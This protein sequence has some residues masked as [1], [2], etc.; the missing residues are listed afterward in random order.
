MPIT[1][2]EFRN[3]ARRL[4]LSELAIDYVSQAR[5]S[6]PARR[7]ESNEVNNTVWR[8]PSAKMG[9]TVALESSEEFT[10]AIQLEYDEEVLEYWEQPPSVALAVSDKRGRL[11]R[12]HYVPDFLVIR[13]S[14]VQVVQ[15]KPADQCERLSHE[16]PHRWSW[17][18]GVADDTAASERFKE[19]GLP[20]LVY[21]S[22]QAHKIRAD[23]YRLLL[24]VRGAGVELEVAR[25][26]CKAVAALSVDAVISMGQLMLSSGIT[27]ATPVVRLVELG[28]LFTDLDRWRLSAPDE[29]FISRSKNAIGAHVSAQIALAGAGGMVSQLSSAEL[30]EAHHRLLTIRGEIQTHRSRRSISR[31]RKR[32]QASGGDVLGLRPHH[33]SKGNRTPRLSDGEEGL[34]TSSLREHYL[35]HLCTSRFAAYGQYLVDHQEA[36][37]R[38][39]L[40][41]SSVPV[42]YPT[43][44]ARIKRIPKEQLAAERSGKRAAAA[45]AQP[46]APIF[47]RLSSIRAF[48]RAHVDHYLCDIH[49]VIAEGEKRYTRRPQLT[50]MR[51][52]ATGAVL[53]V[54][55][56]FMPP[57]RR[58][59]LSVIRDCVRRHGRLPETIVVD[60]GAEFHSEYF[61]VVLA[62]LGVAIQRRPPGRPRYGSTIEAWFHSLKAFLSAQHGNTNN[63][64]RGR[65]A[66]ASHK[67]RAHAAWTLFE[68]YSA[69]DRFAFELFNSSAARSDV[70]SRSTKSENALALFP[71]S[72]VSVAFDSEFLAL[73]A[74]PLKRPL[75][76]D[77]ARGIR[78]LGRWFSHSKLFESKNYDTRLRVFEEPWDMNTLYADVN[79]VLVPCRY[80]SL[81]TV[82]LTKDFAP[83][84]ESIRN[85][86]CSDV[87]GLLLKEQTV[88]S[89][90]L[91]RLLAE[92]TPAKTA[93]PE[94]ATRSTTRKRPKKRHIAAAALKTEY[95]S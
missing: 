68:A 27:T 41:K 95:W 85:L 57:S 81:S 3:Y 6:A 60:N 33:R 22:G 28:E 14:E 93:T 31:W 51:D 84:L 15:V 87:R 18:K 37:A 47:K 83:A 73:T 53:A 89:A 34:L 77:F 54:S 20:H 75:K 25:R 9:T 43:Y 10:L 92:G 8:Y 49:V 32:L 16:Y 90:R 29:C 78:H 72:G 1:A 44:V 67:G 56:S 26:L 12:R 61:E 30:Q 24:H 66:V 13:R 91:T 58:S 38:K 4:G 5:S 39:A 70:D 42:A 48:E 64:A 63:D 82:D 88:T 76:V 35:S 40:P 74:V 65:S 62:R 79:G 69:I 45:A 50:A 11:S 94:K 2:A 17:S 71:E 46:V 59:C 55:L 36:V 52:E 80:A 86:E 19:L 7:V 23:N 21:S